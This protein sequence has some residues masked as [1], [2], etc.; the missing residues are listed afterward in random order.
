MCAS[1]HVRVRA[2]AR[3]RARSLADWCVSHVTDMN[4]LF[5]QLSNF[6]ADISSW[7]TSSVTDMHA[8]FRVRCSPL[9]E[10][11]KPCF[12]CVLLP[13][14]YASILLPAPYASTLPCTLRAAARVAMHTPPRAAFAARASPLSRPEGVWLREALFFCFFSFP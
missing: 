6:N 14:P 11:C 3:A 5:S 12:T 8:M 9:S 2:R 13:A 7:D 4:N 10:P 1:A